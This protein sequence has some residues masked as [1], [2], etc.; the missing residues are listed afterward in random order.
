MTVKDL[1]KILKSQNQN[2]EVFKYTSDGAFEEL[3]EEDLAEITLLTED[4]DEENREYKM[5][6]INFESI[7][8]LEEPEIKIEP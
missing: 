3:E 1:I 4:S 6:C 5:L 2:L 7:D 8:A